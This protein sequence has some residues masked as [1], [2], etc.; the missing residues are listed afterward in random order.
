MPPLHTPILKRLNAG[1][2]LLFILKASSHIPDAAQISP[3]DS[4]VKR[5]IRRYVEPFT[6]VIHLSVSLR[7]TRSRETM[8]EIGVFNV[9][10]TI[11][12]DSASISLYTVSYAYD[13]NNRLT[14]ESKTSQGKTETARY[15]YDPNGK[16]YSK[17]RES[18]A[19]G[20]CLLLCN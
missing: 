17:V 18:T 13:A 5:D 3:I 7:A 16:Q 2:V 10:S 20:A 12:Y 19:E 9:S 11:I 4:P 6:A 14:S 15:R 8:A 1:T